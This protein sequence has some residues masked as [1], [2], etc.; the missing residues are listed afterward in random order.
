MDAHALVP[1]EQEAAAPLYR[2]RS[3]LSRL[4]LATASAHTTPHFPFG[5]G[6]PATL[7]LPAGCSSRGP[8][9]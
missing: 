7:Q 4:W 9:K 3:A 2:L 5:V 8:Q 1:G 6:G